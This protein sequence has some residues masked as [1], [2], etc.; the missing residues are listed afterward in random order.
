MI[1]KHNELQEM[2]TVLE[3]NK[4][5]LIKLYNTKGLTD[6]QKKTIKSY[7]TIVNFYIHK[8]KLEYDNCIRY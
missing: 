4:R 8:L 3:N 2:I 6:E 1:N 7:K 5:D